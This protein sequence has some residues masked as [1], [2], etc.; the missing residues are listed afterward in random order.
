MNFKNAFFIIFI[1]FLGIQASAQKYLSVDK[2]DVSKEWKGNDFTSTKT[3]A[4]NLEEAPQF[5]ILT[6]ILKSDALRQTLEKEEMVTIFAMTDTT[7]LELPEESRDSILGNIKLTSS[8]VK[9][10]SVPGRVDSFSLKSALKKS[11]GSIFLA[12]LEGE[13][14]GVREVNGQLQLIDSE[15]RTARIIASDFYHKN[16]FFHIVEGLVFPASEE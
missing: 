9:Y 12:T 2:T 15:N 8:M 10:L 7:F 5:T 13:K 16:G 3:F 4:E 11:N 14:L 6:G 1:S